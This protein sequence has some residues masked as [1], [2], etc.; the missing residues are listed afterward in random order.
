MAYDADLNS[1]HNPST[2]AVA[3]ASWGGAINANF[4]DM[5]AWT[6]YTPTWAASTTNPTIGNGTLVGRYQR[7]GDFVQI[8]IRLELGSTTSVGS[9][10]WTW[11]TPQ[12]LGSSTL[13]YLLGFGQVRDN[14]GG[15]RY[16]II[17]GNSG[18]SAMNAITTHDRQ[19]LTSGL[20]ITWGASD[21]V[22]FYAFGELG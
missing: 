3:P 22:N 9:G 4:A 13:G 11:S 20:P 7:R 18:A 5:G 8:V 19:F 17:I 6:S 15:V 1:T 16:P 12:S 10:T 2:G 21:S 14:T